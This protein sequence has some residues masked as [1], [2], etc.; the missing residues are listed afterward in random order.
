M[1]VL[2]KIEFLVLDEADKMIELGHFRE[3]NNILNKVYEEDEAF[4]KDALE[5]L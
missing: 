1:Q 2:N 4:T 3:L 5:V